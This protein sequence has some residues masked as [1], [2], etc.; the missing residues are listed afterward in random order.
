MTDEQDKPRFCALPLERRVR[1][2]EWKKFMRSLNNHPGVAVAFAMNGIG[3]IAGAE[4]AHEPTGIYGA[5]FGFAITCILWIPV[6]WTA[7]TGRNG[8]DA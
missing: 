8:Y 2:C 6:L 1:L 5:I 4:R 3:A 7:W